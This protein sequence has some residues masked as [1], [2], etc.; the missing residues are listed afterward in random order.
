MEPVVL[1]EGISFPVSFCEE[2]KK[3]F[4]RLLALA[5]TGILAFET[6]AIAHAAEQDLLGG[7]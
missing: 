2:E 4:K 3:V 6:P 5:L 1:H 7:G